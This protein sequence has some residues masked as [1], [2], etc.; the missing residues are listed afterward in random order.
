MYTVHRELLEA[1]STIL[2]GLEPQRSNWRDRFKILRKPRTEFGYVDPTI[3]ELFLHFIYRSEYPRFSRTELDQQKDHTM[4]VIH[5]V[6]EDTA[7]LQSA[8]A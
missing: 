8:R 5:N 6:V 1:N 7:V 2:Q 3:F 4:W